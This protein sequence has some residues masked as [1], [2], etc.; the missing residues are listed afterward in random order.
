M[1]KLKFDRNQNLKGR[2]LSKEL[3]TTTNPY[4]T[5]MLAKTTK[6]EV[7]YL[8]LPLHYLRLLVSKEVLL[9]SMRQDK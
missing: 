7:N 8:C 5:I 9:M 4:S 1:T 3:L 6:A 2:N